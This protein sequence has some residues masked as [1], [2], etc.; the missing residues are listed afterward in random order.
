MAGP[1]ALGHPPVRLADVERHRPPI[2]VTLGVGARCSRIGRLHVGMGIVT[3]PAG[4]AVRVLHRIERGDQPLHLVAVEALGLPR[5]QRAGGRIQGDELGFGGEL[6]AGVAVEL[7]LVGQRHAR[8]EPRLH[9][10]QPDLNVVRE[11]TALLGTG[12]VGRLKPMRGAGV[13]GETGHVL[14]RGRVGLQ[15]DPMP[16]RAGDPLPG[17]LGRAGDVAPFADL[18]RHL[19][20]RGHLLRPIGDPEEQLLGLGLELERV[21]GVAGEAVVGALH[22]VDQEVRPGVGLHPGLAAGHEDVA[23]LAEVVVV[24]HV[25][26]RGDPPAH[27]QQQQRAHHADE[28]QLHRPV[29]RAQP[30]RDRRVPAPQDDEQRHPGD[31]GEDDPADHHPAGTLEDPLHHGHQRIGKGGLH[32][33]RVEEVP[34]EGVLLTRGEDGGPDEVGHGVPLANRPHARG[35]GPGPVSAAARHG[36]ASARGR[37]L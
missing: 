34:G 6:M 33:H 10:A 22:L 21:T 13:A 25:V 23:A 27:Q 19:G 29:A 5:S 28:P 20:V 35:T 31:H 30:A 2:G 17:L 9:P 15:V 24:H 3:H 18:A 8:R 7:L 12:R 11:M 32:H 14:E 36:P 26:V 4:A 16:R 1:A 37:P